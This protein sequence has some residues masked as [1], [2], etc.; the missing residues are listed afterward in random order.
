MG[1]PGAVD[2]SACRT[3]SLPAKALA[4][5]TCSR[6]SAVIRGDRKTADDREQVVFAKAFA[7]KEAVRQADRSTAPGRPI[8]GNDLNGRRLDC[9]FA[10]R[11][12]SVGIDHRVER[13]RG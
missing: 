11:G 5:T 2:R 1:L 7:G 10:A 8:A 6:S 13:R 9:Q 12:K 4:N 3:A